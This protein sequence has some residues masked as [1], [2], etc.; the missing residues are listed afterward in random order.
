MIDSILQRLQ[1][2][3]TVDPTS[4]ELAAFFADDAARRDFATRAI[5]FFELHDRIP[6]GQDVVGQAVA[7]PESMAEFLQGLS[8]FVGMRES[9]QA[10]LEPSDGPVATDY[11]DRPEFV[12]VVDAA[13]ERAMQAVAGA[14]FV[15]HCFGEEQRIEGD[16]FVLPNHELATAEARWTA[17]AT[18]AGPV[19]VVPPGDA[20]SG[21]FPGRIGSDGRTQSDVRFAM[22]PDGAVTS[23]TG[24][25]AVTIPTRL[26]RFAFDAADAGATETP[27]RLRAAMRAATARM[28]SAFATELP[29]YF[30]T[31]RATEIC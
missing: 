16:L 12:D 20:H 4:P 26:M 1:A 24:T 31:I 28:R 10:G 21:P 5:D 22:A 8:F 23:A 6:P 19:E 7:S 30:W 3:E 17:A 11:S 14:F 13:I 18:A 2:G 15:G 9:L 29:P 25:C 27:W